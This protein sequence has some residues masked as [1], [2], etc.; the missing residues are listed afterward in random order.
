[1]KRRATKKPDSRSIKKSG[2][3]LLATMIFVLAIAAFL[4]TYLYVVQNSNQAVSRAQ[5]W[6]YSLAVAEAGVEE[7][8]AQVNSGVAP[9]GNG[10]GQVGSA[11]GP[12]TRNLADGSYT[13]TFQFNGNSLLATIYSTGV[14]SVPISGSTVTR[15]V[16]VLAHKESSFN[17]GM[18][19]VL[20]VT[21]NGNSI[22]VSSW[23]SYDTNNIQD[24][25]GHYTD[26][27]YHPV[28]YTGTNGDVAV[29]EGFANLGNQNIYGNLYL[30]PDAT[31]ATKGIITGTVYK[32]WN[33]N[34]D[35]AT[36]PTTDTNGNSIVWTPAPGNS[37]H[38]FTN[39]GYYVVTDSGSISVDPGVVVTLKI[40]TGNWNPPSLTI[41]G[42]TTNAG[43]VYAY[44]DPG[45]SGSVDL[46][47]IG[48]AA[49]NRPEN[50]MY[51]GLPGV[52]KIKWS[53]ATTFIGVIYAPDTDITLSGGGSGNNIIG[54][55]IGKSV[56]L[57]GHY[58]IHYDLALAR[59]F[60]RGYVVISWQE[61]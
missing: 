26:P 41:G 14:V 10:W 34:F 6:N 32:D 27:T 42:D 48:G 37:S 52:T 18:G 33:I 49:N 60:S 55:L 19:A 11:Y 21:G 46:N 57:N 44:H 20:N 29:Q 8:M 5:R 31:Y 36:M 39:S 45:P 56:T 12:L 30:G 16:K 25:N 35:D 17:V 50:F 1:M 9:S 38:T 61:L 7:A 4:V 22:S 47:G 15:A 51:F 23:N 3:V 2:S 24:Y 13:T 59:F 54:A 53:G 43:T 40:T 58:D 28:G